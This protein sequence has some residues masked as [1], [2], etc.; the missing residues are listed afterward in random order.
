MDWALNEPIPWRAAACALAGTVHIGG[1]LDEIAAAERAPW[2]GQVA[3]RP[4]VLLGQPTLFDRSRAPAGK[5]TAWA[6][7]HVPNGST[8]DMSTEI[9][10]QIERFAPGFRARILARSIMS[11]AD[12]ER[13]NANLQGG[14]IAG[15]AQTLGQ[16]FLRPTRSMYR[17]P[18]RGLYLCSSST[19]PGG[20]VHGMCGY[21]AARCALT[22]LGDPGR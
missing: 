21:H 5:H 2:E 7:C 20:G 3:K 14:D 10:G 17:T 15:G 16:F 22:D 4:F 1:T 19:P 12:L 11:T 8:A 9:E 18:I 6:Y 13:H